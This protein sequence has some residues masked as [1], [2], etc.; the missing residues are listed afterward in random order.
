MLEE[1]TTYLSGKFAGLFVSIIC[2]LVAL[3]GFWFVPDVLLRSWIDKA[4]KKK[5]HEEIKASNVEEHEK[6]FQINRDS[7][8]AKKIEVPIDA[9]L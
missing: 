7:C 1:A 6:L 4:W 3:F 2:G 8:T 9:P 5:Y